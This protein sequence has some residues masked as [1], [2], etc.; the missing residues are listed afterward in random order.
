MQN[1]TEFLD[2]A[3][4]LLDTKDIDVFNADQDWQMDSLPDQC[5]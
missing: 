4:L 5:L 1:L 3:T 2:A